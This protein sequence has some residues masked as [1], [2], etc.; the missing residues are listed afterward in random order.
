MPE[1]EDI[2]GAINAIEACEW[3]KLL[4]EY[5]STDG[6]RLDQLAVLLPQIRKWPES[7][8]RKLLCQLQEKHGINFGVCPR[9]RPEYPEGFF[10]TA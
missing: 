8:V 10:A 2:E 9:K 7:S 1:N 3:Q 4:N 6:E 5:C